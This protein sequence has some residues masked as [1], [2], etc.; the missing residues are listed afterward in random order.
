MIS[1]IRAV[2]KF[3][4]VDLYTLIDAEFAQVFL[5]YL[6]SKFHMPHSNDPLVIAIK[7]EAKYR[8]HAAA[9]L[10]LHHKKVLCK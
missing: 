4:I 7:T 1:R 5:I 9:M 6:H 10:V 3:L 8:F 2:T